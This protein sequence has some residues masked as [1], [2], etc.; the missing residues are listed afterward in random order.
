MCSKSGQCTT[1]LGLITTLGIIYPC[2]G[3]LW[4]VLSEVAKPVLVYLGPQQL[5][6]TK[7]MVETRTYFLLFPFPPFPLL[8][9][10]IYT[11][12]TTL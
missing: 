2:E 12:L 5:Q 7:I 3:T 4:R 9:N 1:E 8:I 11:N 10:V 6:G